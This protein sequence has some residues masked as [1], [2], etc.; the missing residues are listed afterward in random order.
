MQIRALNNKLD[1]TNAWIAGIKDS[2][3]FMDVQAIG[4]LYEEIKSLKN[5]M[6]VV[7]VSVKFINFAAR[8]TQ[9]WRLPLLRPAAWWWSPM[10]ARASGAEEQ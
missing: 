7:E 9:I 5:Y 1:T 6:K 10:M 2:P 8:G 3:Q 4:K